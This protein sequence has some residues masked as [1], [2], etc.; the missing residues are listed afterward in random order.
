MGVAVLAYVVLDGYDLGVG[1]LMPAADA[2]EQDVM[3]SSIGPF[4]DANETWLVARRGVAARRVPG[5]ARVVL[6]A[7]YFPVVAMLM[8]LMLRGAAFEFASKAEGWHGNSG[9]W[10]FWF[11]SFLHRCHR[12]MLG[13]YITGF[14]PGFGYFLFSLVVAVASAAATCCSA[15]PG[16]SGAPKGVAAESD[17]LDALGLLWGRARR[18]AGES[19]RRRLRARPCAD[20]WFDFPRTCSRSCCCRWR[21]PWRVLGL[22]ARPAASGMRTRSRLGTVRSARSQST[23]SLFLGLA[24]SI[25]PY[26]VMDRI[27]IGKPRRIRRHSRSCSSARSSC[28]RSSS[29]GQRTS[30]EFPRQGE[31]EALRLL[32]TSSRKARQPRQSVPRPREQDPY[33]QGIRKPKRP[34]QEAYALVT[35]GRS[36]R[37]SRCAQAEY[38]TS[39]KGRSTLLAPDCALAVRSVW[40]L[41][42]PEG[43]VRVCEKRH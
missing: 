10:L 4:W 8:G 29:A 28:C 7:L 39:T 6:G 26:V 27:T 12:L 35:E 34:I 40:S 32:T 24:Y 16:S 22:A 41:R 30:T 14:E 11:G 23:R 25:F 17:R 13:A 2:R 15:R 31:R 33:I 1:M 37:S 18:G 36:L 21:A 38:L 20:K 5:G 3:V 19:L 9:N 43:P 42:L